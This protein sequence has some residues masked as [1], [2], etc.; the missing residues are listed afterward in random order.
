MKYIHCYSRVLSFSLCFD[1]IS[2]EENEYV[3]FH[4]AI[5]I[6]ANILADENIFCFLFCRFDL[7][8]PSSE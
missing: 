8:L 6:C 4:R 2:N 7:S 5:D 3:F 1:A